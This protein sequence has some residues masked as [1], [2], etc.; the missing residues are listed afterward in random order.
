MCECCG[1]QEKTK[2]KVKKAKKEK[3]IINKDCPC[4]ELDCLRHGRCAKCQEYHQSLNQKTSC[5]K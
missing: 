2:K 4:T 3:E 1:C 5:G